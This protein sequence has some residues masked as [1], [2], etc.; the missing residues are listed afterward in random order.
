MPTN[1]DLEILLKSLGDCEIERVLGKSRWSTIYQISHPDYGVCA[2]KYFEGKLAENKEYFKQICK[3]AEIAKRIDHPYVADVYQVSFK[4]FT[5]ILREMVEGKTLKSLLRKG[6]LP[7]LIATKIMTQVVLG[8]QA[9]YNFALNHKNLKPSNIFINSDN[10]VRLVDFFTPAFVPY[11]F[12]PEHCNREPLD[13]RSDIYSLGVI[14]Y[15]TL[16]GQVPFEGSSSEVKKKHNRKKYPSIPDLPEEI[17]E[18]LDKTLAKKKKH[19]YQNFMELLLAL[20]TVEKFLTAPYEEEGKALKE[21][22]TFKLKTMKPLRKSDKKEVD[23]LEQTMPLDLGDEKEVTQNLVDIDKEDDEKTGDDVVEEIAD[24]EDSD[25]KQITTLEDLQE[26]IFSEDAVTLEDKLEP[27]PETLPEVVRECLKRAIDPRKLFRDGTLLAFLNF[28]FSKEYNNDIQ[29]YLIQALRRECW[30]IKEEADSNYVECVIDLK[31]AKALRYFNFYDDQI[32]SALGKLPRMSTV[33]KTIITRVEDIDPQNLLVEDEN[34]YRDKGSGNSAYSVIDTLMSI[35]S[36]ELPELVEEDYLQNQVVEPSDSTIEK[37]E[38]EDGDW[39]KKADSAKVQA[40]ED[41]LGLGNEHEEGALKSGIPE[42]L[43]VDNTIDLFVNFNN[44]YETRAWLK[45]IRENTLEQGNHFRPKPGRAKNLKNLCFEINLLALHDYQRQRAGLSCVKEFFEGDYEIARLD[46]GGMATVL[47][48]ITKDVTIIFIRPENYW[49]RDYFAEH[50]Q[51][52]KGKDGKECVYAEVPKGHEFVV[53]IAFEGREEA[54]VYES[55]L[56]SML[57]ADK[58]ISKYIIGIVQQGTFL[59]S[60]DANFDQEKLGYYLMLEY[61]SQGNVEQFSSHFPFRRL[62]ASVGFYI[63]WSMSLT[64]QHLKTKGIIHRDIKPQNIL[65]SDSTVPK[66]GDFGL[67]ITVEEASSQLSDERRR[68]LRLVD[69]EFLH[70]S[71]EKEQRERQLLKLQEKIRQIDYAADGMKEFEEL[72]MEAIELRKEIRKLSKQEQDRAEG[73][74]TRYRPMS[75]EEIALKG[76]FAG[77]LIYAAPEQFS[78]T[79]VLTFQCDVYQLGA[80]A[81]TM[82]TARPP[83]TGKNIAAVMGQILIGEKPQVSDYIKNS[84]AMDA[85]SDV[86]YSMMKNNPEQRINIEDVQKQLEKIILEHFEEMKEDLQY[87]LPEQIKSEAKIKRWGEKVALAQRMHSTCLAHLEELYQ[88]AK[89]EQSHRLKMDQEVPE[90]IYLWWDKL[91]TSQTFRFRCPKCTKK[92]V[93]PA[94][95]AGKTIRCPSCHKRL[96]TKPLS[97]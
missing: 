74:K 18:V 8:M 50:L 24:K 6:A 19:R 9:C 57:A 11:Y 58:K 47:K 54:L 89:E 66:L 1:E 55:R 80:V 72:S 37:V 76:E 52:R 79:K 20:R 3:E 48:F 27:I 78:P 17:Q 14:Y 68:L 43:D 25:E 41:W 40:G 30:L 33:R 73:L 39:L 84:S 31:E 12:S 53:K 65:I 88:Q 4:P 42:H 34:E 62:P 38:D 16:T 96:V 21:S 7:S 69:N 51:I 93:M 75:A 59:A 82:F 2:L 13:C 92:L 90:V 83:V 36:K 45:L 61:A 10:D 5:F 15:H 26:I 49:A 46:H 91:A 35:T 77:S 28:T 71:T 44:P 67:S 94:S 63:L 29:K 32:N 22:V 70:V 60:T 85:I 97:D 56:L 87:A 81:Y 23:L 95:I 86:I 64:L